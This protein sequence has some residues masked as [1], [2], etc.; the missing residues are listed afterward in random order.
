[1]AETGHNQTGKVARVVRYAM[2]LLLCTG[3]VSVGAIAG[4]M[5]WVL[6]T[7]GGLSTAVA[8]VAPELKDR[9]DVT[10]SVDTVSGSLLDGLRIEQ[11]QIEVPSTVGID[12]RGVALDWRPLSLFS[13]NLEIVRLSGE[14]FDVSLST[15]LAGTV[16]ESE[17]GG[18][19]FDLPVAISVEQLDFPKIRL[20]LDG[21][22]AFE[23]S[24]LGKL[25]T[26]SNGLPKGVVSLEA[27][28]AGLSVDR[29]D[30]SFSFA[31][32][33][34]QPDLSIEVMSEIAPDGLVAKTVGLPIE[35]NSPARLEIQGTGPASHW[36]GSMS[37]RMDNVGVLN[38]DIALLDVLAGNP[39]IDFS[40]T[41]A[42]PGQNFLDLSPPLPG[43]FEVS[44]FARLE[45]DDIVAIERMTLRRPDLAALEAVGTVDLDAETVDLKLA[46]D[47][48]PASGAFLDEILS[49]GETFVDLR[50]S[51]DME[52]PDVEG[53][54]TLRNV[55]TEFGN[56]ETMSLTFSA[57]EGQGD[58]IALSLAVETTGF[59]SSVPGLVETVGTTPGMIVNALMAGDLARAN[60]IR[61]HLPA[62]GVDL[63]ASAEREGDS[64]IF[65]VAL[66]SVKDMNSL[67]ALVGEPVSGSLSV[68][69]SDA[70]LS[71]DG[72]LETEFSMETSRLAIGPP[73]LEAMLG[74]NPT[75]T[76]RLRFGP[77][78]GL[79]LTELT[80][81][82][83]SVT[84]IGEASVASTFD[85]VEASIEVEVD[86]ASVPTPD[87]IVF[88]KRRLVMLVNLEGSVSAPAVKARMKG[89]GGTAYGV[90]FKNG[91]AAVALAWDGAVPKIDMAA[92]WS[93]YGIGFDAE[94]A[95]SIQPETLRLDR[96]ALLGTGF[97]VK[98]SADLQN[99]E[100]PVQGRFDLVL[101][102]PAAL[103]GAFGVDIESARI[104]SEV[105]VSIS[106]NGRQSL[107]INGTAE[108][109]VASVDGP[110]SRMTL[111]RL[112]FEGSVRD[113]L[114]VSGLEFLAN[115][116]GLRT[117][118]VAV[119]DMRVTARGALSNFNLDLAAT[120]DQSVLSLDGAPSRFEAEASAQVIGIDDP[121]GQIR[122]D[123]ARLGLAGT[124]IALVA[125]A[126]ISIE[127]GM[128]ADVMADFSALGG[129]VAFRGETGPT[130]ARIGLDIRNLEV[131]TLSALIG[132]PEVSG[133]LNAQ[134]T[135]M[136]SESQPATAKV[137]AQLND[138]SVPGLETPESLA[139]SIDGQL[140]AGRASVGMNAEGP[141]IEAFTVN[142][143]LPVELSL[144]DRALTLSEDAPLDGKVD[145]RIKLE[146]LM[147]YLPLA[148]H[149][150]SGTMVV[151]A[152]ASG[153]ATAPEIA[154]SVSLQ[155]IQYE[156]LE[157]GT[158]LRDL[159]GQINLVGPAIEIARLEASDLET[160]RLDVQG[161]VSV[162]SPLEASELSV[163]ARNFQFVRTDAMTLG[164]D[165][166]LRLFGGS[167]RS[168]ATLEGDLTLTRGEVNLAAA[169]PPSIP[170][171]DVE[172]QSS[173]AQEPAARKA[174]TAVLNLDLQ[175]RIPGQLFVRGRG[176]DSE[177]AGDLR[178]TGDEISPRI[179]GVLTARRGRF[180]VLGRT[181]QL[182]DSAIRFSG[183][184]PIDPLLNIRGVAETP[185]NLTV[186]ARLTGPASDPEIILESEPVM[187]RDEILS[188]LL[189]GKSTGRLSAL[190]AAQLA[191]SAAELSGGG[192]GPDFLGAIR[193]IVG[194]DVL[195]VD[196]GETGPAVRAGR[197]ISDGV[198]VG[199]KQGTA[200]GSGSVEVEVEITPN[201][202]VNTESGTTDSNTGVQFKWDY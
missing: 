116:S 107:T 46:A 36:R 49:V 189:F 57:I 81:D 168:A 16:D 18:I 191:V 37:F 102:D 120:G 28:R 114:A 34:K 183:G 77:E 143:G 6:G 9:F 17:A 45:P 53:V 85:T 55:A 128:P 94:A 75:G 171:L 89:I 56:A 106:D 140:S 86:G 159:V 87:E 165:T 19:E 20:A 66:V 68:V 186:I 126:S 167:D 118:N 10:L 38:G 160:G 121:K 163:T 105:V 25:E 95:A 152:T 62:L 1:M 146:A 2:V 132:V 97:S 130:R 119:D 148:E 33:L 113:A 31:G 197:Y 83:A 127:D 90:P 177:W 150:A 78:T 185:D 190:E 158:A 32:D 196:A 15:Q 42:I 166:S 195:Q 84:G 40:G 82:T 145:A 74:G 52:R 198:Y 21:E 103:A 14:A 5:F 179:N 58:G 76:G 123:A 51:G 135:A 24:V 50:V 153:P 39:A 124:E 98:G 155:G 156:H 184:D 92:G 41:L 137:T 4:L 91:E 188:R 200:P 149:S 131:G 122:L 7:S 13:G 43:E 80:F 108:D 117:G 193:R 144:L 199:A 115:I 154:G 157:F 174:E 67:R 100:L 99:Y 170:T 147:P 139:L 60:D 133:R 180:D 27:S 112:A 70:I 61:L 161:R 30:A 3:L 23:A 65:P 162:L 72:T 64:V 181:F 176:V 48:T 111:S 54:A 142:A 8:V 194:V 79:Q 96:L 136:Q 47:L 12:A 134:L 178:V 138:I 187:P 44:F 11:L 109:L 88:D 71:Q 22:E 141:G 173:S 175:L 192:G 63:D 29:L 59:A 93:A 201:I 125:P 151:A 73:E 129:T 164:A 104:R 182:R 35:I 69:F 110:E 172:T 101:D 169:L 26:L 202:S